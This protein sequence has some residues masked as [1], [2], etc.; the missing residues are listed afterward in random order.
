M[1]L[2]TLTIKELMFK[3]LRIRRVEEKIVDLYP[4][5]EMRCPVHLSIGQEA[6]AVGA[7]QALEKTDVV[8]SNHRA[9]AHYLAKGGDLRS[10]IAEIYLRADGCCGGRGGSM[11]LNDPSVGLVGSVPIVGAPIPLAVGTALKAHLKGEKTVSLVF[12][13]EAASEEGVF[14][15]S[16]NFAALHKLP[17]IFVCENNLYSV[18]SPLS[19][20][21]PKARDAVKLVQ[22]MGAQGNRGDGNDAVEVYEKTREAVSAA[23]NGEGPVFLEFSTY[24]W[25]EHCGPNYDNHIGYRT[26]E[27]FEEWKAKDPTERLRGKLLKERVLSQADLEEMEGRIGDEIEDAFSFAQSSPFPDPSTIQ[28]GVYAE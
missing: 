6:V 23:R 14:Y 16:V 12:F 10:M 8:F 5:Q 27:E 21:V 18:Y 1:P 20:R 13:G 3:M 28:R 17:M 24:R 15:E 26:E 9:H 7:C 11:H 22:A 19:V 2:E 25:R 4:Q